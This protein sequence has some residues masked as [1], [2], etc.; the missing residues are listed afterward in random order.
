[1]LTGDPARLIHHLGLGVWSFLA[2]PA[3]G[4]VEGA[5]RGAP[6][7]IAAGMLDGTRGLITN[8]VYAFSNAT[9]KM[10]GTARK[11]RAVALEV[12]RS[13]RLIVD[14]GSSNLL[15]PSWT[16]L[17]KVQLIRENHSTTSH[18]PLQTFPLNAGSKAMCG[19]IVSQR[20]GPRENSDRCI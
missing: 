7:R 12:V 20:L 6:E 15:Y 10:S 4:L 2:S 18:L 16:I 14:G 5:R 17:A 13:A 19:V 9:A 11:V 3:S 1:M 8:T